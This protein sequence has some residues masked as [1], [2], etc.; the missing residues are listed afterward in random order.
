MKYQI[1]NNLNNYIFLIGNVSFNYLSQ[2]RIVDL[3][4]SNYNNIITIMVLDTSIV[5][6]AL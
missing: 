3:L 2:T 6:G 4:K 1:S 5:V